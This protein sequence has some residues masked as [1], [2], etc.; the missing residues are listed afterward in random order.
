M[1]RE[2]NTTCTL[3]NGPGALLGGI[4][5][6]VDAPCRVVIDDYFVD[7]A[8]PFDACRRYFTIST[9][10]PRGTTNIDLGAGL[11]RFDFTFSDRV[12]FASIPVTRWLVQRVER[13]T[14]P[15]FGSPY[16][17]ASIVVADDPPSGCTA[18][19]A[20][21]YTVTDVIG[22]PQAVMT[23]TSPTTWAGG[24]Y[25][26]V[27]ENTTPDDTCSS[28]WTVSSA[29]IGTYAGVWSGVSPTLFS[30]TTPP[31]NSIGVYRTSP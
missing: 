8:A 23:R 21:S 25:T 11:W 22:V 17:R 16:W 9:A 28:L 26:L 2:F 10:E 18:G 31:F 6:V 30:H 3:Y 5:R 24:G 13:C 4:A 20:E 27:A 7:T 19:Y 15:A 12:E 14:W 29:T 1:R